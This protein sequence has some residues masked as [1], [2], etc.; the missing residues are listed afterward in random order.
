MTV[1]GIDTA[2]SRASV[3]L[4]DDD[5]LIAKRTYPESDSNRSSKIPDQKNH[6]EILI[7][8][9]RAVIDEGGITLRDLAAVAVAIGPGSFTG[10]RIGL[11]TAKG[12]AF[13]CAVPLV[14][15]S[16]LHAYAAAEESELVCPLLDARKN[17]IYMAIF[18]RRGDNQTRLTDDLVVTSAAAVDYLAGCTRERPCALIGEGAFVYGDFFK[19]ALG[20]RVQVQAQLPECLAAS[21]ARLGRE[22]IRAGARDDLAQLTPAYVSLSQPEVKRQVADKLSV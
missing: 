22:G 12:L 11:S 6:S 19:R 10:V 21:V 8:L 1:L 3:A 4:I 7:P 20:E 14:G 5:K 18:E 17:E 2:T 9:I 15:V 13:G 16:T